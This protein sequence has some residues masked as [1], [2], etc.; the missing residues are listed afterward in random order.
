MTHLIRRKREALASQFF[1]EEVQLRLH[2]FAELSIG[3]CHIEPSDRAADIVAIDFVF[4]LLVL[5]PCLFQQLSIWNGDI[6]KYGVKLSMVDDWNCS[7]KSLADGF[8]VPFAPFCFY[9]ANMVAVASCQRWT[10]PTLLV[11]LT[12]KNRPL[13]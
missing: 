8:C 11:F 6:M 4:V 10:S 12:H 13:S 2:S 3:D 9:E 7:D 1:G 5:H